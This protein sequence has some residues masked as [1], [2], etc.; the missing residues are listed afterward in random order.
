MYMSSN[1]EVLGIKL[2]DGID[3][4]AYV[5][6]DNRDAI[7]SRS[8]EKFILKSAMMVQYHG[9]KDEHG[10][11]VAYQPQLHPVNRLIEDVTEDEFYIGMED[12][13]IIFNPSNEAKEMFR[14]LTSNIVVPSNNIISL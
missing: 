12:V 11:I 6:S 10:N 14:S 9:V 4:I 3:V 5:E 7:F 8:M 13:F 2:K 1:M